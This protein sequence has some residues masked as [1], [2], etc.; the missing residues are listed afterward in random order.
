MWKAVILSVASFFVLSGS[1]RAQTQSSPVPY[2]KS[3][4]ANCALPG[5]AAEFFLDG[6][7]GARVVSASSNY[8]GFR[9]AV[10]RK[11]WT[12]STIEKVG[13]PLLILDNGAKSRIMVKL[14]GG[15]GM[16]FLADDGVSDILCQVLV[17]P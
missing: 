1:I 11:Q 5:T 2:L 12:A 14:S 7:G 10:S 8:A 6:K 15:Q 13:L 9:A 17:S 16:A 4:V 3:G